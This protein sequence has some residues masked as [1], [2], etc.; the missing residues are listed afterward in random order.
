MSTDCTLWRVLPATALLLTGVAQGPV[1]YEADPILDPV[2]RVTVDNQ[3]VGS[4]DSQAPSAPS[5]LVA[6]D[7]TQTT[8]TLSW[9]ASSDNVGVTGYRLYEYL[10]VNHFYSYW[11][12]RTDNVKSATVRVTGLEPGSAHRY[13]VTAVDNASNESARS[14]TLRIRTLRP[15]QAYHPVR[16]GDGPVQAK[17]GERF[18][19]EVDALGVPA[20]TF[21]LVTGP[22]GMKVASATGT[23]QWIPMAGDEGIVTATVRA[24]NSEGRDDH[25]FGFRVHPAETDLEPPSVVRDPVVTKVT[26]VGGTLTWKPATDNVGVAGYLVKVQ[27]SG[28]G[29]NSFIAGKS[30][31]PKTTYTITNLKPGAR[32]R[33][34]VVAY[35]AAGN[36][37]SNSGVRPAQLKTL[38]AQSAGEK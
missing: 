9:Q 33:I 19:Y 5:G 21:S 1:V 12:L 13:A 2:E 25:T 38:T 14:A 26:A 35:D 15:P 4:A 6:T 36:V 3:L 30:V 28:R 27:Q 10:T 32:Y 16:P 37:A 24:K 29:H 7:V 18:T 11:L 8:V 22:Q 31:G 34:W 23:V 20:P 17:V